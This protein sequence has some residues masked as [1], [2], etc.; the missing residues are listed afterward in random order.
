MTAGEKTRC[1][2]W[3]THVGWWGYFHN[4][5][6]DFEEI[7]G[8][9]LPLFA[10]PHYQAKPDSPI[11]GTGHYSR[12]KTQ[13]GLICR[14]HLPQIIEMIPIDAVCGD[15]FQGFKTVNYQIK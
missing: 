7:E 5:G 3:S 1:Q 4:V 10:R 2:F 13:L 6:G 15:F 9:F 8:E 14:F 12:E 11:G